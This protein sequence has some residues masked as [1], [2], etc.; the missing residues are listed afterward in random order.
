M[1][2][3]RK[4]SNFKSPFAST[5]IKSLRDLLSPLTEQIARANV[6]IPSV[7]PNLQ[8]V[9]KFNYKCTFD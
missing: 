2:L 6:S 9:T 8:A 3:D 5:I 4:V 7:A 1:K